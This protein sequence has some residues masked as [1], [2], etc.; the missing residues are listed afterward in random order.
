MTQFDRLAE[1]KLRDAIAAGEF[2]ELPGRG[3]PLEL[4][5]LS[6]V[7]AELRASYLLLKGADV[8]PEE[9]QLKKEILRVGDLVAACEDDEEVRR[10]RSR[11]SRLSLRFRILMEKREGSGAYGDYEEKL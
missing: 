2:D 6:R 11:R 10:L 7:P 4:E 8:L 1:Q 5:D 3:A 9:M